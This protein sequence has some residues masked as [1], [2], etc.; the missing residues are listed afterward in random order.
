MADGAFPVLLVVLQYVPVTIA[1]SLATGFFGATA[2]R[3]GVYWLQTWAEGT[4]KPDASDR[5]RCE[6]EISMRHH[7]EVLEFLLDKRMDHFSSRRE[8]EWKVYFAA[9]AAMGAADYLILSQ[10]VVLR[11]WRLLGWSFLCYSL[12]WLVW[13]YEATLQRFNGKDRIAINRIYNILCDIAGISEGQIN[14]Q[15]VREAVVD[16]SM[17]AKE[18]LRLLSWLLEYNWSFPL[19]MIFL[20]FAATVSGF[21]VVIPLGQQ[22]GQPPTQVIYLSQSPPTQS[23]PPNMVLTSPATTHRRSPR[24]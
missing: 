18:R 11:D 16:R 6:N 13:H 9:L 5:E 21:L 8:H 14:A 23:A 17:R 2:L 10:S 7:V 24:K 15:D 19:Q 4:R 20:F 12:F 1:S 3:F 22:R